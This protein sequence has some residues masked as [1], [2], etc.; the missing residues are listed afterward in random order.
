MQLVWKSLKKQSLS[1]INAIHLVNKEGKILSGFD[2]PQNRGETV[3]NSG[4]TW[5]D[6]VRIP[7]SKMKDVSAIALESI[8]EK[9]TGLLPIDRGQ[10]D[11]D[12]KRLLIPLPLKPEPP[13]P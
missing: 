5:L 2:Y 10:R 3:V 12:G 9:R 7:R 6:D 8:Q 1:Y 11:W 13:T 4:D